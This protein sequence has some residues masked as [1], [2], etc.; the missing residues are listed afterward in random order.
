MLTRW[1]HLLGGLLVAA[2]LS[3]CASN[4]PADRISRNPQMFNSLPARHQRLV[5]QGQIDRGMSP[6]AV[7]LAWGHPDR[8][9][10]GVDGRGVATMRWDYATLRPVYSTGFYG[11]YGW[12][13]Y[14]HPYGYRRYGYP[15]MG[16]APQVAYL[17]EHK[18][19]VLFRNR[20][21][22]SWEQSR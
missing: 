21:V 15:Y 20:K 10:E 9:S 6:D 22:E 16:V 3:G 18:A 14:P 19:A 4:T 12:G 1:R 5:E 8:R 17:P 7:F 2:T 11:G 13:R